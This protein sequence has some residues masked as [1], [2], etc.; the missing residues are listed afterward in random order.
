L[1]SGMFFPDRFRVPDRCPFYTKFADRG[2]R[3]RNA[4]NELC[5]KRSNEF[6]V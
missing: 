5:Q 3:T 4:G 1:L 2:G 6:V